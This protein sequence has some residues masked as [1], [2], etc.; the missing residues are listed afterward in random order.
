[1]TKKHWLDR[2]LAHEGLNF[3]LTNRIPRIA[4]TRL[5]G[6]VS[7]WRHPGFVKPAL[8]LW[9][10]WGRLNLQEAVPG[11][12]ASIHD[13]FVRALRPG[14]RPIDTDPSIWCSPCDA[15]LGEWGV[16]SQHRLYQA[17]GFAYDLRDFIG[18]ED[19][20]LWEGGTFVTLRITASMYHRFH[21]PATGRL[22]RIRYFSG[23][24][25]NVNPP[26]L[27]RVPGLF[28]KNERVWMRMSVNDGQHTLALV[29]VAAVLVASVRLH[30]LDVVYHLRHQG[31]EALDCDV[32]LEKGE[33][34]GWFEHGSTI[35]VLAPAGTQ[36]V[37]GLAVG[38]GV[39]MG[40]ALLQPVLKA[41]S[42]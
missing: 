12:Y 42:A 30:A 36:L 9:Q 35:V 29:A 6:R 8:W 34:M 25:W 32:P 4:L 3:L 15:I 28:C 11:P 17:K 40:Q 13:C 27:K 37:P 21:A 16:I 18:P 1:M 20:A 5:M 24:V 22:N 33:E 23:D 39:R 2:L 38:D 19:P 14:A 10:R 26:A 41:A 31:P 7:R